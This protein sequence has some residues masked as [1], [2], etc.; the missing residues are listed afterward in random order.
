MLWTENGF[1]IKRYYNQKKALPFGKGFFYSNGHL[2][3]VPGEI[4]LGALSRHLSVLVE[5]HQ[6]DT[7]PLKATHD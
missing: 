7:F 3:I 6:C 4:G 2:A 5:F 1:R